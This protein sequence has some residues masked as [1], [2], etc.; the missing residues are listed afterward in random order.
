MGAT[1]DA[2]WAVMGWSATLV[3]P[4]AAVPRMVVISVV[5]TA[6]VWAFTVMEPTV[7]ASPFSYTTFPV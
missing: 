2:L 7:F 5:N 1:E 3:V 6:E 4:S